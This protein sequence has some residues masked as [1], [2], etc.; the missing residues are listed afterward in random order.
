MVV[1]VI[2]YVH[3]LESH[4]TI[5]QNVYGTHCTCD[6]A[7]TSASHAEQI[8]LCKNFH[9]PTYNPFHFIIS[10]VNKSQLQKNK[11]H[12]VNEPLV[13][14][15]SCHEKKLKKKGRKRE[16]KFWVI[17]VVCIF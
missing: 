6:I 1:D 10:H 15:K 16:V 5:A 12:R 8:A 14:K 3:I 13:A 7:H 2:Y 4:I 11:T 17:F 9:K